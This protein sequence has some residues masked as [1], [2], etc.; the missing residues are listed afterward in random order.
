[1]KRIIARGIMRELLNREN[2]VFF[3]Q[4]RWQAENIY[5]NHGPV[6]FEALKDEDKTYTI[7]RIIG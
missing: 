2:V 5:S 6:E 7:T 1:M 4:A 3:D